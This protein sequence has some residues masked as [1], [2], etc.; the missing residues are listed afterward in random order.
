MGER[1]EPIDWVK[2]LDLTLA[3]NKQMAEI[4][5]NFR[6]EIMAIRGNSSGDPME[7]M[8]LMQDKQKQRDKRVKSILSKKQFKKYKKEL[9]SLQDERR[10][11][12]KDRGMGK[13]NRM[14][15]QR[16]RGGR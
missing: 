15:G 9:K 4:Q 14:E 7:M 12:L 16:K 8:I 6:A 10:W 3:Q 11:R 13:R 5:E 1:P 2:K